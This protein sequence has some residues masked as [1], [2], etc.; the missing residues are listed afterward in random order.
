MDL[1][2]LLLTRRN[3][4]T[5]PGG[6]TIQVFK[7]A[8][9]LKELNININVSFSDEPDINHD[10]VHLFN[11]TGDT[12][13][14]LKQCKNVL[15]EKVPLIITPIYW[16]EKEFL[17]DSLK[18]ILLNNYRDVIKCFFH[19]LRYSKKYFKYSCSFIAN[20][21]EKIQKLCLE[22]A[23]LLIPNSFAEMYLL[24]KKFGLY[25]KEY[26]VVYNGVDISFNGVDGELFRSTYDISG[27]FVLS[28]AN[29]GIRKNTLSLIKACLQENLP[30][31]LIGNYDRS[32]P[33]FSMCEKLARKSKNLIRFLG[34]I[35]HNSILLKSAYKAAKVHALVSWYET[36]GLSAMEAAVA[37]C[38]IVITKRGCTHEYF[39]EYAEY[40]QPDDIN[41]IRLALLRAFNK[42]K[43][44]TLGKIMQEKFSWR[45]SAKEILNEYLS[46]IS[47]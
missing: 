43:D 32:D 18:E 33:Y 11:I 42:S 10:I 30:L 5:K 37:G 22:S 12:E 8:K 25:N 46:I 21:K 14:T 28:V 45:R 31:F 20:I 7:I 26:H 44:N 9:Y 15:K 29:I 36:P 38:N 4:L 40:C 2:V 34:W 41:S 47:E 23:N 3:A 6:D 35:P 39:G 16:D 17:K 19:W 27:D 1:K 24:Q 13:H